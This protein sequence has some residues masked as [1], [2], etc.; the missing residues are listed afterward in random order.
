[1]RITSPPT[2]AS[3]E[4]SCRA[5]AESTSARST[6]VR[7]IDAPHAWYRWLIRM[8]RRRYSS[9]PIRSEDFAQAGHRGV[10]Q[11]LVEQGAQIVEVVDAPARG[12]LPVQ[13]RP[14]GESA[15][16]LVH[17][18]AP[19]RRLHAPGRQYGGIHMPRR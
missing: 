18:V 5:T 11:L 2:A 7:G 15:C 19:S 14:D 16:T 6:V 3:V 12:Q 8:W 9:R 17:V 10:E 13:E 1:M 4:G